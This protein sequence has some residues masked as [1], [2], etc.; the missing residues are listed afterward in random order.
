MILAV[1]T[2]PSSSQSQWRLRKET[3]REKLPG[4]TPKLTGMSLGQCQQ[5]NIQH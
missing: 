5:A 1:T 4:T 2:F 3:P